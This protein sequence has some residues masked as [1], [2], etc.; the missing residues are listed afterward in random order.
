[1]KFYWI[2][3]RIEQVQFQVFWRLG[4]EKLGDY[5]SNHNPPEHNIAF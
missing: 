2:N 4:P 5:H 1:M 3:D